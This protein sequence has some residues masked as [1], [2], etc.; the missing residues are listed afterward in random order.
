MKLFKRKH[1]WDTSG[2]QPTPSIPIGQA[3]SP[4]TQLPPSKL[5]QMWSSSRLARRRWF[6]RV[7]GGMALACIFI[8]MIPLVSI[9]WTAAVRGGQYISLT[10]IF[11]S[12]SVPCKLGTT[13]CTVGGIGPDFV[14]TLILMG[15]SAC[16]AIPLGILAA[17][18]L[19]EYGKGWFGRSVS[20]CMDVMSGVPSIV[21]GVF[22]YSIFL[23]YDQNCGLGMVPGAVVLAIIMLPIVTR[24]AEESLKFVPDTLREA[25][26]AL[27]IPKHKVVRKVVL[28]T[29]IAPI[30]TGSLLAVAR[31]GGETAPLLF[32]AFG[33]IYYPSS[34][35]GNSSVLGAIPL[36]IYD[37]WND[38]AFNNQQAVAWGSA[39]VLILFMLGLSIAAR[40][41][42]NS[43]RVK[44]Q[45]G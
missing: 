24:T 21:L 6:N 19:A 16:I 28:R 29:S 42:L 10:F 38:S 5:R 25:G 8:A 44:Y 43:R 13:G 33:S 37:A 17:V 35:C 18:Y 27:G 12:V 2:W 1:I 23:L 40:L 22:V 41:A 9:L 11:G 26:Y 4:S 3:T 30:A 45:N 32:T 20:F 7:M 34:F 15:L 14:G 36:L 31:A 39:L